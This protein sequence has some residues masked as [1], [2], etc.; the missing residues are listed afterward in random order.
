M[1]RLPVF[2]NRMAIALCCLFAFAGCTDDTA[3]DGNRL[4]DGKYPMTFTAAVDGLTV[5]RAANTADGVW[6]TDNK[7][8]VQV[9]NTASGKKIKEYTPSD[10]KNNSASLTSDDPFYWQT[11][12]ET[13]T[14]SAWYCGDGS[15]AAGGA[16]AGAVPASWAVQADQSVTSLNAPPDAYQQSDFLYAAEKKIKFSDKDQ[17]LSFSHQTARV[18]INIKK[19]EAATEASAIQ[20]V[21]I[22]DNKNLALSGTYSG[23]QL[24]SNGNNMGIITPKDITS[25][26]GSSDILRT[27]AALVIPQDMKNKKFIAITLTDDNTYY[28]TP[29]NTDANLESGNQY[30]Y[31]ITVKYGYLDMVTAK[32]GA[33]GGGGSTDLVTSKIVA[34]TFTADKLKMGDYFYHT[35][36][37]EWA[38][39]DGG[40]RKIYTDGTVERDDK[41]GPVDDKGTCIGIVLKVGKDDSGDWEDDCEYKLKDGKTSM[42]D[43]HGY[44]LAL[45]DANGGKRCKWGSSG[46][47]VGNIA[48]GSTNGF[49]GYKYTQTIKAYAEKKNLALKSAFPAVYYATSDEDTGENSSGY[50]KDNPAPTNS[51]G[52][53]LPS[54]GQCQYWLTNKKVLLASIN[55]I[56]GKE[57][58]KWED[59]H[60]SSS[61]YSARPAEYV[62]Y[63]YI[64]N[65]NMDYDD[66]VGGYGHR[67]R[68]CLAF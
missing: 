19:G 31:E 25:D 62:W 2:S 58:Y 16:N 41:V 63:V 29:Q 14:V 22:G 24:T 21:I 65:G 55:K 7:I 17:A 51:S 37:G 39:S 38:T 44:V 10:I 20:S 46:T 45:D 61:E 5:T 27:Y 60:W 52:W 64:S 6:T 4:P 26:N 47:S 11:T 42:K 67:V 15:T 3:T 66:K 30:T 68:S 34:E 36:G 43:I 50:E 32:D 56:K 57:N 33:W 18:V 49:Y 9:S 40:L 54:V 13:K 8:A 48:G 1:N 59:W 28:Y 35:T 53:F 12:D 23:N